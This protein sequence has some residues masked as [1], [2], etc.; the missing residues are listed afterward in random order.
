MGSKYI[1]EDSITK[2]N[3]LTEKIKNLTER[4]IRIEENDFFRNIPYELTEEEFNQ[5]IDEHDVNDWIPIY[6]EIYNITENVYRIIL[7]ER[8]TGKSI[9]ETKFKRIHKT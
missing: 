8:Y 7:W 5:L 2:L 6:C 3:R 4:W 1:M 9:W